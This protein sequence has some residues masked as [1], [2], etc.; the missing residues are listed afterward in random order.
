MT[1]FMADFLY[2]RAVGW[3]QGLRKHLINWDFLPEV[4]EAKWRALEKRGSFGEKRTAVLTLYRGHSCL[5][6][7]L[8]LSEWGTL[9]SWNT[10]LSKHALDYA[11]KAI[12]ENKQLSN[13]GEPGRE[14]SGQG[15]RCESGYTH[16]R[17]RLPFCFFVPSLTRNLRSRWSYAL[18]LLWHCKHL[19]NFSDGNEAPCS[20]AETWQQTIKVE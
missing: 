15:T 2:N 19:T 13:H 17:P 16:G 20:P 6:W 18:C 14:R 1:D 4:I 7:N 5:Y 9:V 11:A 12:S 3:Q 8:F 10:E